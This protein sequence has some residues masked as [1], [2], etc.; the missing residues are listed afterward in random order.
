MFKLN[1]DASEWTPGPV[2]ELEDVL[3]EQRLGLFYCNHLK[4]I[5][6]AERTANE[7]REFLSDLD[8]IMKSLPAAATISKQDQWLHPSKIQADAWFSFVRH[9]YHKPLLKKLHEWLADAQGKRCA[10]HRERWWRNLLD[11]RQRASLSDDR[12]P[13]FVIGPDQT[14][15]LHLKRSDTMADVNAE[16]ERLGYDLG[17]DKLCHFG[18]ASLPRDDHLTVAEF[19][20][21]AN[22]SL[23][24]L[25]RLRGGAEVTVFEQQHSLGDTGLL[26]L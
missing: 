20:L 9:K 12:V 3:R 22:S 4:K 6:R 24:V 8:Q 15:T 2:S 11:K 5:Q 25:G 17:V 7:M 26:D 13:I 14:H 21:R 23:Q 18:G 1:P 10:G 19:G 16:V